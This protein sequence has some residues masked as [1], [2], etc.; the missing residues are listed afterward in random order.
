MSAT[1]RFL[2]S[3]VFMY[4]AGAAHPCKDPCIAIL[5]DVERGTL[6]AITN[7]EVLQEILYR[8]TR[9][10]VSEKGIALCRTIL[11]YPMEVL[12][13]EADDVLEATGLLETYHAVGLQPRDAI[14]AATMHRYGTTELLS[15]DKHFDVLPFLT[16]IDPSTYSS[17]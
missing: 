11:R 12:A 5:E 13:V 3:N 16:R 1:S 15:A 9:I 10:G 8:Y 4:A 7:T 14:H 2:D 17:P 6:P